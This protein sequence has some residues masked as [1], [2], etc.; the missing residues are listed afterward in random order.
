MMNPGE[1]MAVQLS[2]YIGD[3]LR[4][5]MFDCASIKN[6]R[7]GV[8]KSPSYDD[9]D[10]ELARITMAVFGNRERANI[11]DLFQCYE[12]GVRWCAEALG[13]MEPLE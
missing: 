6:V 5:L 4:N 11:Y 3:R 8:H 1:Q 2:Q 9:I 13:I 10:L 12:A 7:N